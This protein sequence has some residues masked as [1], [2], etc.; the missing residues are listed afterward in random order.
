MVLHWRRNADK[1]KRR[2]E[3]I[4]LDGYHVGLA[5]QR[6]QLSRGGFRLFVSRA[7]G[8]SCCSAT[9]VPGCFAS[10]RK[11]ARKPRDTRRESTNSKPMPYKFKAPLGNGLSHIDTE[12]AWP[13]SHF[14]DAGCAS[15]MKVADQLLR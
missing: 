9:V 13:W 3:V 7:V 2:R 11:L 14:Q 10:R 4:V 5:Y 6:P 12:E 8:S 1:I 15:E